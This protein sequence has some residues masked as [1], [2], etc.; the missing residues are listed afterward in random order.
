MADT[1]PI[2]IG[3]FELKGDTEVKWTM[4]YSNR[5]S[6]AMQETRGCWV[7]LREHNLPN[8]DRLVT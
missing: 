7:V 4:G 8:E 5:D 6:M 2:R 3:Y 1:M